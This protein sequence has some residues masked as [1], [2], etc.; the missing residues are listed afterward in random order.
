ML[1]TL[2]CFL[3]HPTKG[4]DPQPSIGGTS[5]PKAGKMFEMLN[6]VYDRAE[7]ECG[8]EISFAPNSKG[9]QQNDCRDLLLAY[10]ASSSIPNGRH[11]A[12]RLQSITTRKAGLG[13]LFLMAGETGS[14]KKL[15]LSRFPADH[16]ILAEETQDKLRVEFL[17]KVFM[18][19]AHAYKAALYDWDGSLTGIWTGRA[20]DRQFSNPQQEGAQY[21]IQGFLASTLRTTSAA[22]TM[23][24][25]GAVRTA[26]NKLMHPKAKSELAAAVALAAGINGRNISPNQFIVQFG[27]SE[28]TAEAVRRSIGHENL[29]NEVFQFDSDEF[30]KH[31]AFRIVEL[32]NGAI[33]TADATSFD[34]VFVSE[35]ISADGTD[36]RFT[37][38]GSI[39]DERLRKAKP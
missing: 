23:R 37:T 33:L 21:W 25:A 22:G 8:I 24:L 31:V 20:V 39:V 30:N 19:S 13:L 11:I 29:L 28:Y 4:L 10:L 38:H 17:E 35:P 12:V 3:T 32:S 1:K 36:V 15:V 2:H 6:A 34:S 27:L 5:V 7:A 9:E 18:K 14:R 16:G 26:M